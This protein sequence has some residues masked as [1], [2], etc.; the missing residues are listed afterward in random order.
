MPARAELLQQAWRDVA[1]VR[2][3]WLEPH[4]RNTLP[5]PTRR[6]YTAWQRAVAENPCP[7]GDGKWSSPNGK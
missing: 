6:A 2:G 1:S 7:N 4:V 3:A 5:A